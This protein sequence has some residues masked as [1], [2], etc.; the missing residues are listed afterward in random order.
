MRRDV[1]RKINRYFRSLG[2]EEAL[3]L[4]GVLKGEI[5]RLNIRYDND[6]GS[7]RDIRLVLR[8][9]LIKPRELRF[10][11]RL[12]YAFKSAHHKLFELYLKDKEVQDIMPLREEEKQWFGMINS[13]KP[14][15]HQVVFGRWDT[16]VAFD[17]RE[18]IRDIKFLE[19]NTVGIGGVHYIPAVS[20]AAKK[21]L[22]LRLEKEI[23]PLRLGFQP[24]VRRLLAEEAKSHAKSIGRGRL[25]VAVLENRE[26]LG[27]TVEMPEL[28]RYFHTLGINAI[29]ADPRDLRLRGKEIYFKDTNIDIIYRDAEL[30]ELIDIEKKGHNMAVLK[31]AF[32]NNQVISSISGELD[33]KSG[34]EIFTSPRFSRFFTP[35]ERAIFKKYLPWTRILKERK[36]TD[37]RNRTVNLIAYARK[38]KDKLV[39]KPNRAYGGKDVII[40]KLAAK[41][42]WDS[43]IRKAADHPGDYVVQDLVS[44]REEAFPLLNNRK[45]E[46]DKFYSVSGFVVTRRSL[47]VLGRFSKEMVVNVARKGGIIPALLLLGQ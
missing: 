11:H 12:V 8:P 38:N 43:F 25:N 46:F 35:A 36:T 4:S 34:F 16:N 5:G 24:D 28:T 32:V 33:H 37:S 26:F 7:S 20:E 23:R 21:I 22:S 6:D 18:S 41:K 9:W 10:L 14:Q 3:K 1:V 40:G 44:I 2:E 15:K 29:L 19:T 47:A 45:V 17:E 31:Q 42:Q 30:Q 39:I 27:G 13:P